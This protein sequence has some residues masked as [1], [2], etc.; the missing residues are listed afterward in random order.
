MFYLFWEILRRNVL[1]RKVEE[2]K[3]ARKIGFRQVVAKSQASLRR[4]S[5]ITPKIM[6]PLLFE[7]QNE[8]QIFLSRRD[9][10]STVD[11]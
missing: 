6:I 10:G 5:C 2:T 11:I 7:I 3:K 9:P 4:S 1:R 8:D